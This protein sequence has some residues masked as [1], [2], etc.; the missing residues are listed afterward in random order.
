MT[1]PTR[2]ELLAQVEKLRA[3]LTQARRVATSTFALS[4]TMAIDAP[5]G[6]ASL[7]VTGAEEMI[8]QVGADG[9]VGYVNR[10]MARLLGMPDRRAAIGTPVEQ[11][12]HGPI[13]GGVLSGLVQVALGSTQSHVLERT[14]ADLPA[15]LIPDAGSSRPTTDPVLRFLATGVKGR[16]EI[17]AQDVTQI[18]WLEQTFSRYVSP[19]VID[20]MQDMD[21]T[22][23]L[24]M[25]RRRLTVLFGDLRGF[26]ALCQE[27]TPEQ[28]Q[29]VVNSFLANMVVC[30]EALDGTVD[31][32]VG[33]EVMAVFGAPVHQED[34]ALR[35]L[36]CACEMQ[37]RHREWMDE[38]VAA[39]TPARSLGIGLAT[40]PVVVGNVGTE[41]RM[42][43]TV[44]GH[45][46]N[47]AA[48][49]C[50]S[51]EGGEVLTVPETHRAALA[52]LETYTGGVPVPRL[53]FRSKGKMTFKN[54]TEPVNVVAAVAKA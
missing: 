11:W 38:R 6:S 53:S 29:E 4:G 47:L 16:V 7:T 51:A 3:E 52:A 25:E 28:I 1:E 43:Y 34:H 45:T 36:V 18:R 19:A 24:R 21:G 13:G 5:S 41:T 27:L 15:N 50:G 42:D 2:E 9:L 26:T 10:P 17:I 40:G 33:D 49:L 23:L 14:C 20:R 54:V 35:A 32:F 22:D 31:K 46:V 44:L 12:D 37:R 30:V 8:L 48:R 39:G